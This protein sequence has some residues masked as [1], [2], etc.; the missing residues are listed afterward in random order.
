MQKITESGK[1]KITDNSIFTL[2][3]H[4]KLKLFLTPPFY[5]ELKIIVFI[6]YLRVFIQ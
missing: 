6:I 3:N 5:L 2:Y 4:Y 1:F